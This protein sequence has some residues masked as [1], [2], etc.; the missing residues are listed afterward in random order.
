MQLRA[1]QCCHS[2]AGY[3][4]YLGLIQAGWVKARKAGRSTRKVETKKKEVNS[5]E[6]LKGTYYN[7]VLQSYYSFLGLDLPWL[8]AATLLESSRHM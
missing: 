5:D 3:L 2:C 7:Q 4:A 8:R 6:W 1:H